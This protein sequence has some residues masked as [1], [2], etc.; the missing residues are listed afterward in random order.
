MELEFSSFSHHGGR[1]ENQDAW[2]IRHLD[3]GPDICVCVADGVGGRAFGS[4]ASWYAVARFYQLQHRKPGSSFRGALV[5]INRELYTRKLILASNQFHIVN[6]YEA[7]IR[8]TQFKVATTF[9][10]GVFRRGYF[11]GCHV[12][13][14]RISVY[15]QG[16]LVDLTRDQNLLSYRFE[17]G[18]GEDYFRQRNLD[19]KEYAY[20]RSTLTSAVGFSQK[21]L[22]VDLLQERARAGD[23]FIFWSDGVFESRRD[24]EYALNKHGPHSSEDVVDLIKTSFAGGAVTGDNG[25]A[26]VVRV[27]G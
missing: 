15:R 5:K 11:A 10:G 16:S 3:R 20:L 21:I 18:Y 9:S 8:D 4:I 22:Q 27:L 2:L 17:Y 7:F 19:E 14:T 23:F 6:E 13:D 24:W 26:C 12:G 25:T 1:D